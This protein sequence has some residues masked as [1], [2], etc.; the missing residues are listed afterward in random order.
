MSQV[1]SQGRIVL[2]TLT[3]NDAQQINRRRTTG[4]AIAD[5]IKNNALPLS[6]LPITE[7]MPPHWPLGAQAHI[8]N[9]AHEGETYPCM[10]VRVWPDEFGAGKPGINGQVFLDGNDTY[11]V[12]SIAE[13]PTPQPNYWSWPP[14]V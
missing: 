6:K 3:A 11:W 1:P 5:R 8:G 9:D 13:A 2:Y 12:T 7:A 4:A 10:I 14:R